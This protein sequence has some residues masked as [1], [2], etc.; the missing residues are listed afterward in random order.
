MRMQQ[1]LQSKPKD[2]FG[3]AIFKSSGGIVVTMNY[4]EDLPLGFIVSTPWVHSSSLRDA[5][6]MVTAF[7]HELLSQNPGPGAS[8]PRNAFYD[9]RP[10]EMQL[11]PM[12]EALTLV[13]GLSALEETHQG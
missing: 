6:R 1:M 2:S 8:G 7:C 12:E 11:H 9:A 3:V 13:K 10:D 5:Q 4:E